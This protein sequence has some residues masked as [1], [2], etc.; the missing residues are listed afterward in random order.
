MEIKD[1]K[2]IAWGL[3][4]ECFLNFFSLL[5][6][7]KTVIYRAVKWVTY[8]CRKKILGQIVRGK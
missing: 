1:A 2:A 4:G 3:C 7:K 6:Q 8:G 5:I